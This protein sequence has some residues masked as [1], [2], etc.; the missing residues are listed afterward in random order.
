MP[1]EK[2]SASPATAKTLE[3]QLWAAAVKVRGAVPPTDYMHVCIGMLLQRYL[4]AAF[5][6]KHAE[7]RVTHYADDTA[8]FGHERNPQTHR[9][10]RMNLSNPPFNCF[11]TTLIDSAFPQKQRQNAGHERTHFQK[12][13]FL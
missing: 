12:L 11:I 10:A 7:L 4:S 8:V 13:D 3:V 2:K 6:K 9:L 1:A 5:E